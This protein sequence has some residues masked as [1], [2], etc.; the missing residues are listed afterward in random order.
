MP[1]K[2]KPVR[3]LTTREAIRSLFPKKVVAQ[4]AV[5]SGV[6]VDVNLAWVAAE[7]PAEA[8]PRR[9]RPCERP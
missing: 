6:A 2:K 3:K 1:R 4:A 7:V 9:W 8:A 5:D